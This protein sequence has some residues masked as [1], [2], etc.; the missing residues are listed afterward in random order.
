MSLIESGVTV[1]QPQNICKKILKSCATCDT[2]SQR[3]QQILKK[4][5]AVF[6]SGVTGD[7]VTQKGSQNYQSL[8]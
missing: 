6:K 8:V 3:V 2:V 4:C 1:I 5:F 7:T